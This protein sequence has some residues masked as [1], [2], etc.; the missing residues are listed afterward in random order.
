MLKTLPHCEL[1]QEVKK[2]LKRL[3]NKRLLSKENIGSVSVF[4]SGSN[5]N[6]MAL[7]AL[8]GRLLYKIKMWG[9]L[10]KNPTMT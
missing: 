8:N 10:K 2:E 6:R 9:F 3:R 5:C 7:K 1:K 4:Q